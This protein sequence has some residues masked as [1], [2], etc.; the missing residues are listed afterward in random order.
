MSLS[1]VRAALRPRPVWRTA[2]WQLPPWLRGYVLA[3][4]L[5]AVV[6]LV[7]ASLHWAPTASDLAMFAALL[8]GG[9][10]SIEATRRLGEPAGVL[11]KDLLSTWW[12]PIAVLLPP[13]YVLVAAAVLMALTQWRVRRTAVYRRVFTAAAIGLAYLPVSLLFHTD[14]GPLAAL[15]GVGARSLPWVAVAAGCGV[16]AAALNTAL[17]AVAVKAADPLSRWISL[18]WDRDN[19]LLDL[20]EL[21]AGLMVAVLVAGDWHWP[22]VL[23][24]LP[25]M[26][27][28]QRGLLHGQLHAAARIDGKT[29]LLNAVTWEREAAAELAR[30]RRSRRPA[31]VLLMDVDHFKAVNDLYGHLAGDEVLRAIADVLRAELREP[32]LVGR[33]G[34]E[35]FVALLSGV[36]E[37]AARQVAERLRQRVAGLAV[38]VDD[39]TLM[40]VTMSVGVAADADGELDVPDLLASADAALYR[41]K[42]AGRDQVRVHLRP[43]RRQAP[44]PGA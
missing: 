1:G 37:A 21:C 42:H 39:A 34:G 33:F 27:L 2:V 17:V 43:E 16:L 14:S 10:A 44:E 38:P 20:T 30:L 5:V 12:L 3:L 18:L 40:Q 9:T 26:L 32:D 13:Q 11:T 35:E 8:G 6:L 24:A 23:I 4:P 41:A 31:A 15:G 7:V 28:L 22:L 29:Q 19:L 25:P 36:D